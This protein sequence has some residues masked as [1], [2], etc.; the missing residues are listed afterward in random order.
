[1][2]C[3]SCGM[4]VSR[5][6]KYCQRCGAHLDADAESRKK[7]LDEYLDGL[8]WI[9]F[10]GLGMI[11]GGLFLVKKVLGL[12]DGLI[13]AYLALSSTVFLINFGLNFWEILPMMR[14][15]RLS[16]D[17]SEIAPLDTSELG[18]EKAR[19]ALEEPPMSVT[20]NTTRAFDPI[21]SERKSKS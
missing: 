7:R 4:A 17:G 11:L 2:Y 20:E 8:F 16:E 13:I 5:Q 21:Y 18:P 1:M 10:L 12:S 14:R 19:A 3:S 15:R 9:S 6:L